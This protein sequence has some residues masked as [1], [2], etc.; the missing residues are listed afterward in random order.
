MIEKCMIRHH[1]S[2]HSQSQGEELAHFSEAIACD[3]TRAEQ[4]NW[5]YWGRLDLSLPSVIQL[6][7]N[8]RTGDII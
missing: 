5:N 8:Y 4:D 6:W 1:K 7:L 2:T 3:T